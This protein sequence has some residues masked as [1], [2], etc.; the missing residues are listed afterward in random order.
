V[1]IIDNF[2]AMHSRNAF[3]RPRRNLAFLGGPRRGQK[4]RLFGVLDGHVDNSVWKMYGRCVDDGVCVRRWSA[5][6]MRTPV[7]MRACVMADS[8]MM[9]S[10]AIQANRQ[11]Y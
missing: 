10:D 9:A 6:T 5:T 7:C 11:R 3:E 2:V 1:L 4:V 8:V